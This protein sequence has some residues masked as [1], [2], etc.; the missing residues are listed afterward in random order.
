M[1]T[2]QALKT[3]VGAFALINLSACGAKIKQDPQVDVTPLSVNQ[4]LEYSA[5]TAINSLKD[6]SNNGDGPS[7]SSKVITEAKASCGEL[8][9][10][11]A[12]D[13][14]YKGADY[15]SCR[16]PLTG[17]TLSGTV[18]IDY[19]SPTCSLNTGD[20]L[21]HNYDLKFTS[22]NGQVYITSKV[23]KNYLDKDVGGGAVITN[24]SQAG[25]GPDTAQIDILGRNVS[26]KTVVGR[27]LVNYSVQT[28][29]PAIIEG[30]VDAP[31]RK[32]LSGRIKVSHNRI[33]ATAEYTITDLQ[34]S[35]SCCYPISGQ[36]DLQLTG[37]INK[38]GT[39]NITSCGEAELYQDGSQ[40]PV[41]LTFN[42]CN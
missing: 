3:I 20:S 25:G 9:I 15:N 22:L 23:Q 36:M 17:T 27:E 30:G 35:S 2:K 10:L 11:Q 7:Q 42:S 6:D 5:Q 19:S 4:N 29:D 16:I 1:K 8:A 21:Q 33:K 18:D 41:K 31:D 38:S 40:E 37:S 14:G 32:I 28:E 34:Y 39:I 24:I 26:Y 13:K 12:C